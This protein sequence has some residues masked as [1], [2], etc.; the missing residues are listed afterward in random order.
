MNG[1]APSPPAALPARGEQSVLTAA[2]RRLARLLVFVGIAALGFSAVRF[3]SGL[4]V[5]IPLLAL[6]NLRKLRPRVAEAVGAFGRKLPG[7]LYAPVAIILWLGLLAAAIG[8]WITQDDFEVGQSSDCFFTTSPSWACR[9]AA[10]Y[11]LIC[12]AGLLAKGLVD[13]KVPSI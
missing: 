1:K 11:I 8:L 2:P 7:L 13:F 10:D 6:L 3:L 5:V 12:V 4:A 9:G